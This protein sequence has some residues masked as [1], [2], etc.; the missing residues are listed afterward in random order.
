MESGRMGGTSGKI[1]R[2]ICTLYEKE[3]VTPRVEKLKEE[4]DSKLSIL[5]NKINLLSLKIGELEVDSVKKDSTNSDIDISI[6]IGGILKEEGITM[7]DFINE[8]SDLMVK[9]YKEF[10][11]K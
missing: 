3:V 1:V 7:E 2:E 6:N 11:D 9:S 10:F 4:F 5:E 8:M